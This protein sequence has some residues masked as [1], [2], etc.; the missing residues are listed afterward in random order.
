[1]RNAK[2]W[3]SV[4]TLKNASKDTPMPVKCISLPIVDSQ[5]NHHEEQNEEEIK[6]VQKF[7]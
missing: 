5:V 6:L 4:K 2:I 1:M 7:N 3:T